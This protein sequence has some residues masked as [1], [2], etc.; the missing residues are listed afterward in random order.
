MSTLEKRNFYLFRAISPLNDDNFPPQKLHWGT[1][2]KKSLGN[3]IFS[4]RKWSTFTDYKMQKKSQYNKTLTIFLKI[5]P[6]K[7]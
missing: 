3:K 6:A 1:I 4:F 7:I 2:Q 5:F